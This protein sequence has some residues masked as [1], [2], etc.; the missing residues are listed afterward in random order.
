MAGGYK[1][2]RRGIRS[3]LRGVSGPAPACP[4]P[5]RKM[6]VDWTYTTWHARVSHRFSHTFIDLQLLPPYVASRRSFVNANQN[7]DGVQPI[8][9]VRHV[10]SPRT[11]VARYFGAIW[12]IK[13]N[14]TTKPDAIVSLP[15]QNANT[16]PHEQEYC[17]LNIPNSNS[18]TMYG[19]FLKAELRNYE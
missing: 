13:I 19:S 18:R 16:D 11:S 2:C 6:T 1:R 3:T 10:T 8:S 12:R 4:K 7:E 9:V 15:I 14:Y 17:N 5:P